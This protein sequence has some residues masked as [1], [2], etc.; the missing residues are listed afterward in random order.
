ML[1]VCIHGKEVGSAVHVIRYAMPGVVEKDLDVA[2]IDFADILE[3]TDGGEEGAESSIFI[4]AD[5][6]VR[7]AKGFLAVG[8]ESIGIVEGIGDSSHALIV[9]VAD[10]DGKSVEVWGVA[11]RNVEVEA[12]VCH[13]RCRWGRLL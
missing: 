2:V 1:P 4:Q 9:F 10:D 7:Y 11:C 6:V 5:V 3:V 8:G 12:V 13:H